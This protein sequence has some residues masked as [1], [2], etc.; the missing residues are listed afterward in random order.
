[1][2]GSA[3]PSHTYAERQ[4]NALFLARD[5]AVIA[6]AR[7]SGQHGPPSCYLDR[8]LDDPGRPKRP[9]RLSDSRHRKVAIRVNG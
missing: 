4:Q 7:G 9:H 3:N 1:M 5:V 8:L 6:A 2:G